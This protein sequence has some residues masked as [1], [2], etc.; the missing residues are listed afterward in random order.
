M[1]GRGRFARNAFAIADIGP[2]Q[3]LIGLHGSTPESVIS[4][5]RSEID[6]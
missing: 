3:G 6:A 4:S 1:A 5:R 2:N